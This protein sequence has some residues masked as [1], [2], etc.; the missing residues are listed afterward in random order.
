MK[1]LFK[2]GNHLIRV[3]GLFAAGIGVFFILR[4]I[5]VPAGF[6]LYGHYRAGALADN[7]KRPATFA[8]KAACLDCHSEVADSQKKSHH[9]R[10][11]CEACHGALA[12]HADDPDVK[13]AK[14]PGAALCLRCHRAIVGRPA[15]FPQI[16]PAKH[17]DGSACT[18]CHQPHHP[19]LEE[20]T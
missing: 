4:G 9:A 3:A 6:G 11:S 16:D 15:S 8:G 17:T 7:R 20:G 10:L 18:T 14:L 2:D 12:R 5:L 13:P 19:E 1:Q